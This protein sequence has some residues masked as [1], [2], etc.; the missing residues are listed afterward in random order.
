MPTESLTRHRV[1]GRSRKPNPLRWWDWAFYLC[2]VRSA[3]RGRHDWTLPQWTPR[4]KALDRWHC[5]C[6]N[7]DPKRPHLDGRGCCGKG[8]RQRVVRER[9]LTKREL[10]AEARE[11]GC[12]DG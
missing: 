3:E 2:A 10:R 12:G 11:W 6:T 5:S 9:Q 8:S 7:R 4:W 1:A